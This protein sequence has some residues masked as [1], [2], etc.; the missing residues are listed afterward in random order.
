VR[1][2]RAALVVGVLFWLF[3]LL[4]S[5]LGFGPN[6]THFVAIGAGLIALAAYDKAGER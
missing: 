1:Y 5:L 3:G 2:Y 4:G 6:A